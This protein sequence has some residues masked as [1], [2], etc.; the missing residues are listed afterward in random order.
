[1]LFVTQVK[2]IKSISIDF[3][4]FKVKENSIAL[5]CAIHYFVFNEE[6]ELEMFRNDRL[7][8]RTQVD[9]MHYFLFNAI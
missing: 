2:Q 3:F 6:K 7:S 4:L 5:S 9:S 1:M 8:L